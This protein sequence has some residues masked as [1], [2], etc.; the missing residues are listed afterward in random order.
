MKRQAPRPDLEALAIRRVR[1]IRADKGMTQQQ[2]AE[3]AD[4]TPEAI[5][6][7]ERGVRVPTLATIGKLAHGL[8]V[9]P[10]ELLGPAPTRREPRTSRAVAR[11]VAKLQDVDDA[12]QEAA[13]DVVV[14][15]IHAVGRARK[16]LRP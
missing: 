5:T 14:A 12:T 6:R 13:A 8:G 7:V 16:A 3:R 1:E 15:F 2:L 4:L 9:S 10:A 11:V